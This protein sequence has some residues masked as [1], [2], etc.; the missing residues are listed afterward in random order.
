MQ[1]GQVANTF[2]VYV[3]SVYFCLHLVWTL[4]F[5]AVSAHLFLIQKACV[6]EKLLS[7]RRLPGMNPQCGHSGKCSDGCGPDVVFSSSTCLC[8]QQATQQVKGQHQSGLGRS[9]KLLVL[10]RVADGGRKAL[11]PRLFIQQHE[12]VHVPPSVPP[13]ADLYSHFPPLKHF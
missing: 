8:S 11:A 4:G 2:I 12:V 13:P 9:V 5:P 10:E 3:Y 6:Q 1:M 7:S